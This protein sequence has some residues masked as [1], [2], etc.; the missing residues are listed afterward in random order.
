MKKPGP[1]CEGTYKDG[2]F[3]RAGQEPLESLR[4]LGWSDTSQDSTCPNRL[5]QLNREINCLVRG[6]RSQMTGGL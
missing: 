1:R 4:L 6:S 2:K 5:G 3:G